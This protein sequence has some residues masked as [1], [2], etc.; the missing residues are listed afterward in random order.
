[1]KHVLLISIVFFGFILRFYSLGDIPAGF[2]RDEAFFGYN[3]YS[4]LKTGSEITGDFLPLHLSSYLYSPA[5]YSYLTIP[6]I[7][8][9]D[10]NEFSVRFASALFGSLSV[11]LMYFLSLKLFQGYKNREYIALVSSALLAFAPW[12]IN[13]SRTATENTIVVFLLLIGLISFFRWKEKQSLV[14]LLGTFL[15]FF[16]TFFLYQAPRAF[17]PLFVPILF[18][19]LA[20]KNLHKQRFIILG[21]YFLTVIVPLVFVLN[22]SN[23][24]LRISSLSITKT[25]ETELVLSE[26]IHRDGQELVTPF[27]TRAFHNKALHIS[28]QFLKNYFSH[29][30][31]SFLFTDA[32]FPDRYRIPHVGLLLLSILPFLMYGSYALIRDNKLLAFFLIGWA[33]VSPVGSALTFD[34]V[35][36]LQRTLFMLPPLI[37]VS[38][39]GILDLYAKFHKKKF[40]IVGFLLVFTISTSFLFARYMHQYYVHGPSYHPWYRN[41]GYRQ[42]VTSVNSR[43]SSYKYVVITNRESAPAIFFLFFSKYDPTLFQAETKNTDT[44]DYDR[45]NFGKYIFSLEE[46]PAREVDKDNNLV[47]TFE[48]EVLYV[49]SGLCD[50]FETLSVVDTIKRRDG[51]NVFFVVKQKET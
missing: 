4:L 12:H 32:G 50:K 42:L 26:D 33:L 31:F 10:L 19:T 49:N 30:G 48:E 51:S 9:F 22:S 8:L 11:V 20:Y 38:S 14:Y 35:P 36:N 40:I 37:F 29:L 24:S 3:S 16:G 15:L 46:C 28:D 18:L 7:I 2:H 13:L 5:G 44:I 39:F 43:M 25:P 17:F 45:I 27:L 23:L 34:D 41:D 1:M 6:F 47:L 21:L